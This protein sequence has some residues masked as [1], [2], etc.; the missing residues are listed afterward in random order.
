MN[1]ETESLQNEFEAIKDHLESYM[2]SSAP[3]QAPTR[4]TVG[5]RNPT[6]HISHLTQMAAKALNR[7]VAG[8]RPRTRPKDFVEKAHDDWDEIREYKSKATWK[9]KGL[10]KG[11]SDVDDMRVMHAGSI[12]E[13]G[14]TWG[15]SWHR[16][17]DLK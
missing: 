1:K 6:R 2:T 3:V 8:M 4:S 5:S 15:H 10:E 16:S 7:D 9:V 17:R 14:K 13:L 12:A 11:M